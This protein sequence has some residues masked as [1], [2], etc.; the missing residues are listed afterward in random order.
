VKPYPRFHYLYGA[1]TMR[2]K[3][4]RRNSHAPREHH[5]P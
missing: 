5:D 2:H 3:I 4:L 1:S